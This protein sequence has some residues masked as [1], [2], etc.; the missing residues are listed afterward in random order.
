MSFESFLVFEWHF[1]FFLFSRE[2]DTVIKVRTLSLRDAKRISRKKQKRVNIVVG[3]AC[4]QL[5]LLVYCYL[6]CFSDSLSFPSCWIPTRALSTDPIPTMT[7]RIGYFPMIQKMKMIKVHRPSFRTM[8]ALFTFKWMEMGVLTSLYDPS[9][10]ES[11]NRVLC[12]AIYLVITWSIRRLLSLWKMC[13]WV[14]REQYISMT[15][16][17]ETLGIY[18]F[19]PCVFCL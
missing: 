7:M 17:Y 11:W 4:S 14:Q 19:E 9:M 13:I 10:S 5:F 15:V 12:L 16:P 18:C 2:T 3:I 6:S 8:M 1:H